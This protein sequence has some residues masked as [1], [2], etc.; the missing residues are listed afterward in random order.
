MMARPASGGRTVLHCFDSYLPTT[1]NWLARQLRAMQT[2]RIIT[3]SRR[4]LSG[5]PWDERFTRIHYPVPPYE[6]WFGP[7]L[8]DAVHYRGLNLLWRGYESY[9]VRQATRYGVEIVHSNFAPVAWAYRGVARRLGRPHVVSFFGYDYAMLPQADPI[10]L[11]R[12]AQ[13]FSQAAAVLAEG[14]HAAGQLTRLGCP[15]EKVRIA[16]IGVD[17]RDVRYQPRSKPANSLRLVQVASYREK[18]GQLDTLQAYARALARCPGLELTFIGKPE[19]AIYQELTGRVLAQGLADKVR[20]SAEVDFRDLAASLAPFDAFIHPSCHASDGDC[21]GGAPI[22]LLDAQ[23]AGLPAIST[24]HCDI[25]EEVD[26]GVTGLLAPEHDVEALAQ[27]IETLYGMPA[28]AFE[29]FSR[30]ARAHV[31]ERFDVR[32]T[33]AHLERVYEELACCGGQ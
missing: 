10:W 22:V 7:G 1:E 23:A 6:P 8:R 21:E 31:I 16:R 9:V 3:A 18:K 2:T 11:E 30:A 20:F 27:S 15:A 28:E 17:A 13:L 4:Y 19:G 24:T 14:P 12:Y 33:A 26:H 25:P 5:A 29:G 32:R